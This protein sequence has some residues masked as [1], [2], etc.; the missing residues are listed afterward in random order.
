MLKVNNK[1]IRTTG[2]F[3]VNF[4]PCSSVS[5]INFEQGCTCDSA[6]I[7]SEKQFLTFHNET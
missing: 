1:G 7:Y 4:T 6:S 2:V 3:I 5:V